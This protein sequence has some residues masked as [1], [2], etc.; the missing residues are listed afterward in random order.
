M[1]ATQSHHAS[2]SPLTDLETQQTKIRAV[3]LGLQ[4]ATRRAEYAQRLTEAGYSVTEAADGLTCLQHLRTNNFA[5]LVV[6]IKLKWGQGDGVIDMMFNEKSIETIP[7]VLLDSLQ[8]SSPDDVRVG[9]SNS[10]SSEELVSVVKQRLAG[11]Q[12]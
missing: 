4:D 11:V 8:V 3:L 6:E 1:S 10:L 2:S 9:L 7:T 5:V 12:R